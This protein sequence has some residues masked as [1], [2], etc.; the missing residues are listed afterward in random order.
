MTTLQDKLDAV[1][2]MG[3]NWYNRSKEGMFEVPCWL[4]GIGT[5][6]RT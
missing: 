5:G 2:R 6:P 1:A 3:G 4:I